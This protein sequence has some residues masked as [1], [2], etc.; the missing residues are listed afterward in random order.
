[1]EIESVVGLSPPPSAWWVWVMYKT[2]HVQ[3]KNY[4]Q[5]CCS[6]TA[7]KKKKLRTVF[8]T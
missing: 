5:Q 3:F 7:K 2:K 4:T 1:M 8:S 6:Y